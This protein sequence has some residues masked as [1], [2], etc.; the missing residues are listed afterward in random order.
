MKTFF[1]SLL[2]LSVA[3]AG[4]STATFVQPA[5]SKPKEIGGLEFSVVTQSQWTPW[6]SA[7]ERDIILQLRIVNHGDK[8]ILF[9]TFDS[10]SVTITGADGKLVHL[11]GNRDGTII[12]PNLLLPPGQGI[13]YPLI[14]KLGYTRKPETISLKFGDLTGSG[15]VTSL[16]PGDHSITVEVFPTHYDFEKTG[17]LPGPLWSGKG[18][19]GPVRFQA[20]FP[21]AN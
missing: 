5:E 2:F 20:S 9:P 17:K 14:A 19:T 7:G 4:D 18:M 21:A 3:S 8:A 12:T 10:F 1:F 6:S 11:G 16:A 13:S 15:S